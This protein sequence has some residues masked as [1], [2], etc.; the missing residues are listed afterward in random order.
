MDKVRPSDKTAVYLTEAFKSKMQLA[1]QYSCTL[2]EAPMGYGKTKSVREFF[3]NKNIRMV[4]Q[5]INDDSL[6]GFWKNF[7]CLFREFDI[8][9]YQSLL[10]IGFPINNNV[11][12]TALEL[13]QNVL[14][15]EQIVL[16]L[17]DYHLADRP[18]INDF[19]EYILW[20]EIPELHF[21]LNARYNNFT[22]LEELVLKGYIQH[23][24]KDAL[25]FT[26]K[27][28]QS[29][30]NLC[31][32]SLQEDEIQNLYDYTEGWIS[33][34]YL[35]MLNYKEKRILSAPP[36]IHRL[37]EKTIFLP[38]SFETREFLIHI[39]FFDTFNLEQA[40][41]MWQ[42]ENTEELLSELVSRNAFITYDEQ[43]DTFLVHKIFLEFIQNLFKQMKQEDQNKLYSRVAVWYKKTKEYSLALRY[44]YLVKD[45]ESLFKV[46]EEDKG[47]SL[48]NENR[49]DLIEYYCQCPTS[50]RGR[51]PIA[52]LIIAISL[53]SYNELEL[54]T[55]V[56]EEISMFIQNSSDEETLPLNEIQGELELLL[57]F[58]KYNDIEKI[59]KHIK[60]AY[61][62]MKT[63]AR[64][65]DARGVWTFG[66]P[67][68][69]YLFHR[70]SGK[71]ERE[72][73]IIKEIQPYYNQIA[74]GHGAG[75]EL[76]MEA[77][78]DYLRGD[79]DNAEILTHKAINRAKLFK[80]QDIVICAVFLQIK[81]LLYKGDYYRAVDIIQ[82][83]KAQTRQEKFY[84]LLDTI[85]LCE[86][87]LMTYVGKKQDIPEWIKK[88]DFN[89][90]RLY[91]PALAFFNV[92][93]GH[94]LLI[95]GEYHKLLGDMDY[96]MEKASVFPNIMAQIH[97]HIFASAANE[98]LHRRD[99]AVEELKKALD[100][101]YPDFIAMPFV[102]YGKWI[103]PI[104]SEQYINEGQ[105]K[106]EFISFVRKLYEP[107][108]LSVDIMIDKE[109]P[110][111]VI[112]TKRETEVARLV[113]EGF[114]NKEIGQQLYITTNTV[115]TIM[116]RMF[117]KLG[118]SSRSMLKH[119]ID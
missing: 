63:P 14:P 33:A 84:H 105:S 54:F 28:I 104:F 113:L 26:P 98:K 39:C 4:F 35:L 95:D 70:A 40:S 100:L 9:C 88:G 76:I 51:H 65:M 49:A 112:L 55:M 31:G 20:N 108:K 38:L 109:K 86:V 34:L 6:S 91:F 47:Q 115:K 24:Q 44:Y 116:K 32:V 3:K 57:S 103:E 87:F 77:E 10:Q 18:E 119:Y 13:L 106:L 114:S 37:I 93:Y 85:D 8:D 80:Q 16:V 64:F 96:F 90:G 82:S 66:A 29:Y 7:C 67:S 53:F 61:G 99:K 30:Y 74:R 27:E 56:C 111:K 92:V 71:L 36:N 75:A 78:I 97:M 25:E 118:I 58:T 94:V 69:V 17:D 62:L 42:K 45:F 107:Y 89:S 1:T 43:L 2:V 48:L 23:I 52:L 68:A 41:Y 102:I 46:L 60:A 15:S 50:I 5:K 72:L 117:E 21:V 73:E 110:T 19:I 79:F 81:L 59:E 22:N 101:A 11:R 83:L 12:E